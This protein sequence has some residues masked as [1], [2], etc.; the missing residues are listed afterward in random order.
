MPRTLPE[1]AALISQGMSTLDTTPFAGLF[2]ADAVYEMP[3][4]GERIE[5]REA[6]L[7]VLSAGG[8]RARALGLSH[9][10]VTVTPTETGLVLELVAVGRTES[11]SPFRFPSSVGLL[12]ISDGSITAYRDYPNV[13]GAATALG[14]SDPAALERAVKSGVPE[15]AE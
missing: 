5:G 15:T 7:E 11:G 4:L 6:I 14:L 3:F 10:E 9:T 8:D 13:S 2:A 1:I 12:T